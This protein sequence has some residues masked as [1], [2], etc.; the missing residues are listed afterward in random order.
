MF[1]VGPQVTQVRR[2]LLSEQTDVLH[3]EVARERAEAEHRVQGADA[4]LLAELAEL[5]AHGG[6]AA[7][8]D[9]AG[10]DELAERRAA[11]LVVEAEVAGV[12]DQGLDAADVDAPG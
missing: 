12:L 7:A 4:V 5:L 1:G 6:G 9:D 11:H 3:R 10:V 2:D 8:D